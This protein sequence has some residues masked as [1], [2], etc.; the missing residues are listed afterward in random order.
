MPIKHDNYYIGKTLLFTCTLIQ[1]QFKLKPM[2]EKLAKIK[3]Y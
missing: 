3:D 1:L 2:K